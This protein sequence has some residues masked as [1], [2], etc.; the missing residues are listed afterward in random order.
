MASIGVQDLKLILPIRIY[1]CIF[2]EYSL[3]LNQV[4]LVGSSPIFTNSNR[5]LLWQGHIPRSLM[6]LAF[7]DDN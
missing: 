1:L 3:E 2:I 7:K 6:H 4:N 5:Q